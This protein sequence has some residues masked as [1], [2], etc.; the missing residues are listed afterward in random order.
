M[1]TRINR[2]NGPED[3]YHHALIKNKGYSDLVVDSGRLDG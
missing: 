3:V 1:I 2:Y